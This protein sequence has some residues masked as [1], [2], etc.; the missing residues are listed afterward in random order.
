[1]TKI[2][3]H[4]TAVVAAVLALLV[5]LAG[6]QYFVVRAHD[7]A[8]ASARTEAVA[9]ASSGAVAVLSYRHASVD[10]DLD[11]ATKRL[12]GQFL[13]YY[14]K[15]SV[16]VVAPAAKEKGIDTKATVVGSSIVK[17]DRPSM[18]STHDN[19]SPS[20]SPMPSTEEPSPSLVPTIS[21][22]S[23]SSQ[24]D[25]PTAPASLVPEPTIPSGVVESSEPLDNR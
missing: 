3:E 1:M 12:T 17:I 7:R 6:Y 4:R 20:L 18:P 22:N 5:A 13:D 15:F 8:V 11:A 24:S 9:A 14:K 21:A 23:S 16:T 2:K 19:P 10:K 25:G